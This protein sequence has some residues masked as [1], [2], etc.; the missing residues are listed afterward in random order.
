MGRGLWLAE[1]LRASERQLEHFTHHTLVDRSGLKTASHAACYSTLREGGPVA[2][3]VISLV[4]GGSLK[5]SE[6]RQSLARSTDDTD[7]ELLLGVNGII[8]R[9]QHV[10]LVHLPLESVGKHRVIPLRDPGH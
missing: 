1:V 9:Q 4:I 8:L 3:Q 10:L 2:G 5:L 6:E 7:Q